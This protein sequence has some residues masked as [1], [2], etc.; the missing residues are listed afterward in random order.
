MTVTIEQIERLNLAH[1]AH[2]QEI[3]DEAKTQ[4]RAIQHKH[5]VSAVRE[6]DTSIYYISKII[7]RMRR[8]QKNLKREG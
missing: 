7:A 1:R 5:G 4:R 2:L 6:L 3:I 8:L